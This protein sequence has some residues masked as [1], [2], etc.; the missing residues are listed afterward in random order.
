M[1][2]RSPETGTGQPG[3]QEYFTVSR[4][5]LEIWA[6]KPDGVA[7]G[8]G[9]GVEEAEGVA[10]AVTPVDAEETTAGGV[11]LVA[12]APW[13]HPAAGAATATTA[14][15]AVMTRCIFPGLHVPT[16]RRCVGGTKRVVF[17]SVKV[18]PR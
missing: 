12:V 2:S 7:V 9:D 13:P 14:M 16:V 18:K 3:C 6:V 8:F 4:E 17:V 5:T 15:A 10:D 11:A 1:I